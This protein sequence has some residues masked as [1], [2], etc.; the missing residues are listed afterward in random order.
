[1]LL[2]GIG[3]GVPLSLMQTAVHP[4]ASGV[5]LDSATLCNDFA[6]ACAVYGADRLTANATEG[7]FVTRVAAVGS[8]FFLASNEHTRSLA[9]LIPIMHVWY[10]DLKRF[11]GPVKPFVV[12]ALW[13]VLIFYVPVLRAL[14]GPDAIDAIQALQPGS[15]ATPGT[16]FL[17]LTTLSHAADLKDMEED[18]EGGIFTPASYMG[19]K[20]ARRYVAACALGAIVLHAQTPMPSPPLDMALLGI[21]ISTMTELPAVGAAIAATI[22]LSYVLIYDL[23]LLSALLR[24][25]ESSHGLAISF[26]L[27]IVKWAEGLPPPWKQRVLELTIQAFKNGD[28][29]GSLILNLFEDALRRNM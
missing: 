9:P 17:L 3:I 1:M 18:L 11:I 16:L 19:D 20:E 26:T 15:S 24:S 5:S 21:S 13:T 10:S 12:A 25:T 27:D 7:H 2:P 23:E 8:T 4:H 22:L 14:D 28:H 29:I 6:A